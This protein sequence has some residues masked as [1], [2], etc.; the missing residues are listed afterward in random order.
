MPALRGRQLLGPNERR[1]RSFSASV[2]IL[3][4]Q[5]LGEAMMTVGRF[6]TP[7]SGARM[8]LLAWMKDPRVQA[9]VR[10]AIAEGVVDV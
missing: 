4:D 1:S 9:A 8:V 2:T 6:R 7:S 3:E 10:A 5:E